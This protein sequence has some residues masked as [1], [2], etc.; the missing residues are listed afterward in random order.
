MKEPYTYPEFN[1]DALI[2]EVGGYQGY[3]AKAMREQYKCNIYIFEPVKKFCDEIGGEVKVFNF[4]LS[5][6]TRTASI[7]ISGDGSSLYRVSTEEFQN[8]QLV[9]LKEFLKQE[10]ITHVDLININIE[11]EEYPLLTHMI[12]E[13]LIPI[14]DCI[15]IQFHDF[16][17]D[18]DAKRDNIRKGLSKTH[19]L[20]WSLDFIWELWEKKI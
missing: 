1:S 18:C 6:S 3:S 14:F 8:I 11:G 5:D 9:S 4:G 10:E 17:P 2:F 20:S 7:N 16:I 15:Q 12:T 19:S 13:G